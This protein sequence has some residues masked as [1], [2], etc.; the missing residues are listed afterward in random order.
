MDEIKEE[1]INKHNIRNGI[2]V[3]FK[4]FAHYK[5]QLVIL[6]IIGVLSAIGNGT[7]PYIAGKFFDSIL[8]SSDIIFLG[9]SLPAYAW[10]LI[11]WAVV[12][13]ITSILDWRCNLSSEYFAN[14][15][16]SD[17]LT[18]GYGYLLHLPISFHKK[19][20]IG[21]IGNM[22]NQAANSLETIVGKTVIDL[23]PQI[24]SIIIALGI[25]FYLN[26]V[27]TV[28]LCVG[29]IAYLVI[30]VNSVR[31]LAGIQK[32]FN[33]SITKSYG[34]MNDLITNAHA[35]KQATTEDFENEKITNRMGQSIDLWV[36]LTKIWGNLGFYQR[37]IILVTQVIVFCLSI[38]YIRQGTMTL[39]ELLSFN[40]YSAMIFGP[41]ITIARNWQWIQNGIINIQKTEDILNTIPENY[42]PED[43]KHIEITGDIE[44]KDVS[45][46]YDVDKAVLQNISFKAKAGDVIALVGESGV[47]K[48]TLIDLISGYHFPVTG[49]LL[50]DGHDIRKMNLKNLRKQIA[51]VPQEVVLFNDTIEMNIKYG[52]FK[53]TDS[54]MKVAARKAHAIDFIEKFPEQWQQ[55]VGERGVKLSVGQKQRVAIARAIL[56]NPKILILD[57]PTAALDAGSEKIITDSLEE[58]MQ[59]KTTFII[60]HR[61]S[62]VRKADKI[63]VLKEGKIIEEGTH[64]DL[65]MVAGGEYK[66]LYELQ[67]GLTGEKRPRKSKKDLK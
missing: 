27:L 57:E 41:F 38:F 19:N 42:E 58:L 50:I 32:E 62:T 40:A 30:M 46:S 23:S 5:K 34:D 16:W 25:T 53:A 26:A 11:L 13:C 55:V 28:V 48:S 12:Q 35:V 6:S 49:Q 3:L 7:V 1:K 21:E 67:I 10:V 8:S 14:Q 64:A 52:N 37:L 44:F 61:L 56:R 63:L 2:K 33:E 9:I 51:V 29:L 60:A 31:P 39:G 20:K 54:Q 4:Y 66:R 65:K 22:I 24:L 17:Y 43:S 15:I 45:Y 59:G 47:G 36:R 18:T